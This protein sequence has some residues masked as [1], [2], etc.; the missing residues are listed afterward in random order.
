[1]P[2]GKQKTKDEFADWT[3]RA[4]RYIRDNLKFFGWAVGALIVI[5]V[6]TVAVNRVSA[7]RTDK[8]EK[9][10]LA[11]HAQQPGSE[12][13]EKALEE[14]AGDY[15]STAAGREA[16]MFLGDDLFAKGNFGGAAKQYED[17][18]KSAKNLPMLEVAALHKLAKTQK[19]LGQL[20]TAAKTYL[21]AADSKGNL[22][23]ADSLYQAGLC[24]EDMKNYD[25][26]S[27]LYRKVL[28]SVSEGE[29]RSKSEERILWLMANGHI[30]G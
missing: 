26:A 5:F 20:D 22:N 6:I 14:V 19:A 24:Y 10:L 7:Y 11:A 15:G 29:T 13:R 25:E 9:A 8:A 18:A 28:D 16:M 21:A 4:L 2:R 17:L 3:V 12:A 23:R 30:T 27:K 1:M